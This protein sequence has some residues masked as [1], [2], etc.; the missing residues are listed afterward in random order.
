MFAETTKKDILEQQFLLEK[1][2]S[3]LVIRQNEKKIHIFYLII[4]LSKSFTDIIFFFCIFFF[5]FYF[6]SS[7]N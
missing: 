6:N 2:R 1:K 5:Q 3:E 7:L 4:K